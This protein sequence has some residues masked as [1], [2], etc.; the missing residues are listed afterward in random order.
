M[1][2]KP[3]ARDFKGFS[4]KTIERTIRNNFLI[5]EIDNFKK[6]FSIIYICK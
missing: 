6:I 4:Q 3:E 5:N 1:V 2:F